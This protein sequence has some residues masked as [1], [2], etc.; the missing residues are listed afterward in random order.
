M[1][2]STD[3]SSSISGDMKS[4]VVFPTIC[5]DEGT[6]KAVQADLPPPNSSE[7]CTESD[8]PQLNTQPETS[9]T[10]SN[11]PTAS[12]DDHP[13]SSPM[14]DLETDFPSGKTSGTTPR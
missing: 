5:E 4:E 8:D 3:Q 7:V 10:I 1:Q 12:V 2:S 9:K 13:P 6:Q 14:M 11:L